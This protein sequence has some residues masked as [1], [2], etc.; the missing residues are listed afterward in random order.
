MSFERLTG[1]VA[2]LLIG[3]AAVFVVVF[4]MMGW[5]SAIVVGLS[6]PL[7][8]LMVIA[9]LRW[10]EIPIHQM[11]VTGLIIALGLL[12]DNAI[13]MVDAVGQRIRRGLSP[14]GAI[15]DALRH[16]AV[17]LIGSTLT[18][19]FAFAPIALMPG[20]AGEFVGSIA[21]SVILAISSS[22]LL[23]LTVVPTLAAMGWEYSDAEEMGEEPATEAAA[24]NSPQQS[25]GWW[26]TGL[27]V[28]RIRE[29]FAH[30][31][32]TMLVHPW[33]GVAF[34][35]ILPVLGFVGATQL[36]EQFF[37]PADR[38]QIYLELELPVGSSIAQ[39]ESVAKQVRDA[40]IK[41][42]RI[43]AVHWFL[44]E[45]GPAFYYNVIPRRKGT[46][47]Y[48]QAMVQCTSAYDSEAIIHDWQQRLNDQFPQARI[49][50]RQLEQGP[51]FQAPI[52]V[53]LYGQDLEQL[54]DL[55]DELREILA[56]IPDVVHTATE[57]AEPQPKL[58]LRIDE[59]KA[60][61]LG[62]DHNQIAEQ[63]RSGIDGIPGGS[64]LEGTEEVPVS[65]RLR[66][67]DRQDVSDVRSM[68]FVSL[69]GTTRI[70]SEDYF[71]GIPLSSL[72][73]LS[74][75]PDI[76]TIPRYNGQRMNEVR[77]YVTAGVLPSKVLGEFERRLKASDFELPPGFRRE[78]GG[79]QAER[80]EAVGNLMANVGVL[81]VLMLAT[82]VL[83]FKSF[84]LA[85][86]IFLVGALSMG[87]G[88]GSLW[89][90]GFPFGFMA[91]VGTMGLIGVAI[92]DSIVVLAALR[93]DPRARDGDLNAMVEVVME[94]SRHVLSTTLT[95][96]AG[97][98]PLIL[99]GGGFWPPLAIAIAG[100][101]GGATVLALLFVPSCFRLLNGV[102][103]HEIAT[104]E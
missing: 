37:P 6:L 90:F 81:A 54:Q 102:S 92:N 97:F 69:G 39:T 32:R 21:V 95:T 84:R 67:G 49:L 98:T 17:P 33:R 26:N 83:S 91:I 104:A 55:G 89:I 28:P 73:E 99:A 35:L 47:R 74:L 30:L 101:V 1:L 46:P 77:A 103:G 16:L 23:A 18:T 79:E 56:E 50:A 93:E 7:S 96:M 62:L 85:G 27:R 22:L 60:R 4:L 3:A 43:L 64:V 70:D 63:L 5:R 10:L 42:P 66:S 53:R 71:Q 72:G 58:S 15:Q 65:V 20:P 11:S 45:S 13:V 86:V 31:L 14:S 12:I 8:A 78:A 76:A 34:G 9:G 61:L 52:E 87:L 40:M 82:L 19:A 80:D 38:D 68:E 51:P 2:N 29:G 48:A 57:L 59:E 100:G 44:G 25:T 36:R 88:L 94:A 75:V 24:V 41:D